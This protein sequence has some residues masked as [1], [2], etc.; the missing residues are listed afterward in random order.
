M[1]HNDRKTIALFCCNSHGEY[2]REICA[3]AAM[4]AEKLGYNL[5]IFTCYG[6]Y[7]QNPLYAQGE[8][9]IFSL[10]DYEEF[11]GI[12]VAGDTFSIDEAIEEVVESL[13]KKTNCP[14]VSLRQKMENV[15]NILVDNM[16]SMGGMIRL[17]I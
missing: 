3:G 12:I 6:N 5:A 15:N 14:V 4:Q 2:Q 11:S 16:A 9:D 7:G 8:K 13:R 1:F 10:P 17:L